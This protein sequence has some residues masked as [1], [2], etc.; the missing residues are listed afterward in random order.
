M[1]SPATGTATRSIKI[2]ANGSRSPGEPVSHTVRPHAN[3]FSPGEAEGGEGGNSQHG[4]AVSTA[5]S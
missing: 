5:A 1:L 2:E 4:L 3:E